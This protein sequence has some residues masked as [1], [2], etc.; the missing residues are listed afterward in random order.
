MLLRVGAPEIIEESINQHEPRIHG[1]RELLVLLTGGL[2]LMDNLVDIVQQQTEQ[3][4]TK[5][6]VG[7]LLLQTYCRNYATK[8]SLLGKNFGKW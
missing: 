7:M 5:L 1:L 6:G 3:V 2:G 4:I 8:H